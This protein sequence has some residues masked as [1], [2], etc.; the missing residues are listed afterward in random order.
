MRLWHQKLIPKLPWNQLIGQH[1]ESCALRGN[2][3]AMKH[4]TVQYALNSR[5]E[6]L[7][8]FHLL[9]IEELEVRKPGINIEENWYRLNYRGKN[10][11]I[12]D[13]VNTWLVKRTHS[14]ARNGGMIY[15]FHDDEYLREC[16]ENLRGKGII[17]SL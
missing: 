7:I 5:I 12:D 9:V 15:S 11:G 17:I 2:G 8:A 3:F 16:I 10:V 14:N 4:S 6:R 1:R 13:S